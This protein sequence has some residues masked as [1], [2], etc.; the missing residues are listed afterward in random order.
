MVKEATR[1]CNATLLFCNLKSCK[2]HLEGFGTTES[3]EAFPCLVTFYC[4]FNFDITQAL[5]FR[6]WEVAPVTEFAWSTEKGYSHDVISKNFIL[7]QSFIGYCH[8][9]N[10]IIQA[11]KGLLVLW[12]FRIFPRSCWFIWS[13]YNFIDAFGII[14]WTSVMSFHQE[15]NAVI[16]GCISK[17]SFEANLW[18]VHKDGHFCFKRNGC[19]LFW[20]TCISFH[21]LDDPSLLRIQFF[22]CANW[23]SQV[24]F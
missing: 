2:W 14:A 3:W 19:Q 20:T 9:F 12:I 23:N 22:I 4:K 21:E 10:I 7:V 11:D 24:M 17:A 1:C 16:F 18:I 13:C 15:T 6:R 8:S 5:S